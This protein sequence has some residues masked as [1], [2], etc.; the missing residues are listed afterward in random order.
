MTT[1]QNVY[2]DPDVA[3]DGVSMTTRSRNVRQAVGLQVMTSSILVGAAD[4]NNSV[5]RMFKNLDANFVP[6]E[7]RIANDAMTSLVINVGLYRPNLSLTKAPASGGDA[8]FLSGKNIA[9]GVASLAPGT[10]WDGMATYWAATGTVGLAHLDQRL[11]EIAGDSLVE[12]GNAVPLLGNPRQ[13]DLCVTA[14]TANTGSAGNLAIVL[15][16]YQG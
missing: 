14:T 6:L 9:A 1:L 3:A 11:F 10:C 2:A 5:Y 4:T 12:S 13:Y 16:G 8:I 7:I 15:I